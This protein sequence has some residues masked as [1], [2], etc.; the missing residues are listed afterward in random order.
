MTKPHRT[1]SLPLGTLIEYDGMKVKKTHDSPHEPFPWT[2]ECGTEFSD[3]W[4]A[5]AIADG[6][7]ITEEG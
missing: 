7:N 4:A 3:E 6:A 1:A 2:S 5:Q